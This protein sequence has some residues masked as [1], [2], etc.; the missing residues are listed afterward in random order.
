MVFKSQSMHTFRIIFLL[1]FIFFSSCYSQSKIPK[2]A[3]LPTTSFEQNPNTTS[4][5]LEIVAYYNQLGESSDLIQVSDFGMTDSGF[6]LQEVVI[7]KNGH[8]TPEESRKAGKSILFINNGIHPGEPDGMDAS[9]IFVR[10]LITKPELTALL[11][12]VTVVVIPVYNIGGTINRSATSRA[13]QNGPDAYGFRGNAKNLDLNRDFVKCDSKNAKSFNA[14]FHKW[15]PDVQ[16]DTHTSNGADY[17]YTMTLIATQKDKLHPMLSSFMTDL[18]LPDLYKN[19]K[20]QNW[21]MVPYV[22]ANGTPETGIYG[23]MD[24]PRYSSGY[25]AMHHTISFMPETHMLKPYA[26]RVWS[27]HAFLKVGLQFM[28][29]NGNRLAEI[30]TKVKDEVKE[31]QSFDLLYEIDKSQ[32]DTILFKGYEAKYK[33]SLVSGLDRL[34]YDRSSPWEKPVAF[35]ND[36]KPTLSIQKPKAYIIP[37]A[38]DEIISKMEVNGVKVDKL[39]SDT[40]YKV[41]LYHIDSYETSKVAYEGHY[42]HSDVKVTKIEMDKQYH[43][44]DFIIY[45][46]QVCNRYIVEMLEPQGVDSWFAWNFFDGILMQKEGFSAYVFEDLAA[47][48]LK[49]DENLRSKLAQKRADDPKFATNAWAQLDFVYKNSPYYEKTHNLYPVARAN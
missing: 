41:E 14:F 43:K 23:F 2:M 47:E 17:Q 20:S 31:Q 39:A 24:H 35:Y 45:T 21:E 48:I 8:F 28:Y 33:P 10:D 1:Q 6:P 49:N 42:N 32:L 7:A 19:M 4:T 29:Q 27:T 38:Y 25:A 15:D 9:M 26:D 11:D 44:G 34:Y 5:Y 3:S 12:K 13:N 37:Q 16:I 30:R 36:Y 18:M 40:V 22:Y 46:N